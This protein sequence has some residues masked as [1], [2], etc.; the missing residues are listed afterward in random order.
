MP[1]RSNANHNE[2]IM[3]SLQ[4]AIKGS[5]VLVI[6]DKLLANLGARKRVVYRQD[7]SCSPFIP[8]RY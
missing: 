6:S 7:L 2:D 4:G 1:D 3:N 5:H 8:V